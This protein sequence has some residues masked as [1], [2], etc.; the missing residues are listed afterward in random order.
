MTRRWGRATPVTFR[1]ARVFLELGGRQ[2]PTNHVFSVGLRD[3][4]GR[5][6][7]VAMVGRPDDGTTDDGVTGDVVMRH[8]D[9]VTTRARVTLL[10]AAWRTARAAG[11]R[12]LVLPRQPG[13][14]VS[15]LA[16]AGWRPV[17]TGWQITA[18]VDRR[19]VTLSSRGRAFRSRP[20]RGVRS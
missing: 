5:V 15:G 8:T 11:F 10:A 18:L 12:R 7:A 19:I 20:G 17:G 3:I 14:P 9:A 1:Q 6:T 4:Q 16:S 2:A 13:D